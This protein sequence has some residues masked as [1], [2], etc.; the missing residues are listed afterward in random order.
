MAC[1]LAAVHK[2]RHILI[3]TVILV[4]YYRIRKVQEADLKDGRKIIVSRTPMIFLVL[5]LYPALILN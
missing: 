3:A 5:L 2:V 4:T 1:I